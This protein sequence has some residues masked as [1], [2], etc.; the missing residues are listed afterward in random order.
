MSE[1]ELPDEKIERLERAQVA[2]VL[3]ANSTIA[4]LEDEIR[5]VQDR[6]NHTAGLLEALTSFVLRADNTTIQSSDSWYEWLRLRDELIN[7]ETGGWKTYQTLEAENERLRQERDEWQSTANMRQGQL[8]SSRALVIEIRDKYCRALE[9]EKESKAQLNQAL[10]A[11]KES[12]LYA[13]KVSGAVAVG[14]FINTHLCELWSK[15]WCSE[16]RPS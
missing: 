1:T 6:H 14:L 16:E 13:D 11:L 15:D 5:R 4:G 8:E 12:C 7:G 3:S 9:R 10:V 2:T